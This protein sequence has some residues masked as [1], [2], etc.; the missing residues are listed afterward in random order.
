MLYKIEKN[1]FGEQLH[2]NLSTN[3]HVLL[4]FIP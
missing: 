2:S 3:S 1:A 4:S